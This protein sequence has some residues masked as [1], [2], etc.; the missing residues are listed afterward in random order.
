V[1]IVSLITASSS[2]LASVPS[3]QGGGT[4]LTTPPTIGAHLPTTPT[5]TIR[6]PTITV[7]LPIGPIH[8]FRR[9]RPMRHTAHLRRT[10]HTT[11]ATAFRL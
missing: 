8:A 6:I 4:I 7:T 10:T 9:I 1:T 5:T 2:A 11:R 3:P